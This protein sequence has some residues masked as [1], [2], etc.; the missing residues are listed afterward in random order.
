[1]LKSVLSILFIFLL[2]LPSLI[3]LE[4]F[5]D[6][7]HHQVCV[8]GKLHLHEKESACFS[9]EFIRNFQD[10]KLDKNHLS[11]N[12]N[13]SFSDNFINRNLIYFSQYFLISFSRGPP[14]S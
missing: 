10:F 9:C 1:M 14:Y 7:S 2:S 6:D 11:F 13:Q 12:D 8:E 4:H 3:S 5:F